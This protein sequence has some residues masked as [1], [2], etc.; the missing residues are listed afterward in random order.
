M[1]VS[2]SLSPYLRRRFNSLRALL[3]GLGLC[4]G[5]L[6]A[7]AAVPLADLRPENDD[8]VAPPDL[9]DDCEAKLRE[10]GVDFAAAELPVK[11]GNARRPTCGA[12]QAVVYR[13]G[14]AKIRY[15]SAPILSCGMAL[16]LAR[17]ERVLNE[18]AER[19]L[20]QS[21]ACGAR[22]HL[23]LPQDGALQSR[24]RALVRERYRRS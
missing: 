5:A 18:E 24:Q 21:V 12:P 1:S 13:R 22:W 10:A 4:L 2:L 16:G 23:Q 19:Y 6:E 9:I 7:D 8:V 3:V 11:A 17:F 15:N 14:P 20:G